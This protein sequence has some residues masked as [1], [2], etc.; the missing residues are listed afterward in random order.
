MEHGGR[1]TDRR[2]PGEVLKAAASDV[3][4]HGVA[5][6]DGGRPEAAIGPATIFTADAPP[7]A[8]K[9]AA[10][11]SGVRFMAGFLRVIANGDHSRPRSSSYGGCRR[12]CFSWGSGGSR[13]PAGGLFHSATIPSGIATGPGRLLRLHPEMVGLSSRGSSSRPTPWNDR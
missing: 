9:G 1:R 7:A 2:T 11:Q 5:E 12:S 10:E 4:P 13:G 3:A 6:A 8:R